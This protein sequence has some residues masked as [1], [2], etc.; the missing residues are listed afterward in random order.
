MTH[1]PRPRLQLALDMTDLSSAL[2]P[3]NKAVSQVDVIECGTVLVLGEGLRAVREVRALYP[4]KVVLADVRIVEAG[5][6]IAK[7]CFDAGA[8]WVSVVAGASL[9]T[10]EQVVTVA[11]D[12]GGEVQVELGE[13]YDV[14]QARRWR[15]LGV[16]HVIVKRSRDKEAAGSLTWGEQDVDRVGELA[17]LGL[18]VTIT[19]GVT[20]KDL[21]TF[22]GAPVGVVIAGRSIV[23]AEDPL[24][25]ATELQDELA[26]VWA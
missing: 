2:R 8:S 6:I 7:H 26:R 12:H 17:G 19:G 9:T 1:L 5:S 3:L 15:D 21:E 22:Q 11:E 10:V 18:T 25:A 20:V 14:E 4:D 13:S 23:E 16:Q 24:A